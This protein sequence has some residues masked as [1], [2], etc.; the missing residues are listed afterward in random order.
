MKTI[1]RSHTPARLWEKVKLSNNYAKALEQIDEQ[2]LHWPDH[3]IHRAKQRLTKLTQ[4]LIRARR[5]TLKARTKIVGI[6]KKMDRRDAAREEKAL[7]A[8]QLEKNIEKELLARLQSGT[9]GDIYNIPQK[10]F[11]SALQELDGER[12]EDII[13]EDEEE[14]DEEEVMQFVA[15]YDSSD[16]EEDQ[17]SQ[18]DSEVSDA[19]PDAGKF[20]KPLV[21]NPGMGNKRNKPEK[22]GKGPQS[23]NKRRRGGDGPEVELEYEYEQPA[24]MKSRH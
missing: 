21:V 19:E 1:E 18:A 2:M 12:E 8:A 17:D 15:K 24:A 16:D 6:K 5:L 20:V 7:A 9:Y 11:N 14:L 10:G 22:K 13:A 3:Q 4:Y 23:K